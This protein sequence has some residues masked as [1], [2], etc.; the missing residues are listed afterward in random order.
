MTNEWREHAKL[1]GR[2]LPAYPDDLQ[3]V[4]H[5]GGPQTTR[6]E[7]EVVWVTVTG[8]D[9]DLFRGRVLNEPQ[10]LQTVGQGDEITFVMPENAAFPIL[11]TESYLRER[12]EWVIHP[13]P[14]CGLSELFDA[15]SEL[16]RAVFPNRPPDAEVSRF[17]ATCPQCGEGLRVESRGAPPVGDAGPA[18]GG[19]DWGG[20]YLETARLRVEN[21]TAIGALLASITDDA[22]ADAALPDLDRA[23]AR[24]D[25]LSKKIESYGMSMEDHMKLVREHYKEYFATNSDMTVSTAAALNNMAFAQSKAPGRSRAIE[26]AIKKVGLA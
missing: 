20:E 6:N 13:C 23:V 19:S 10:N 25:E 5:D 8:A 15:P 17:T 3:V 7:P 12:G 2:F 14:R 26:A 1:K 16:I 11:V 4:V 9:G 22:S 18:R 21:M 24:H